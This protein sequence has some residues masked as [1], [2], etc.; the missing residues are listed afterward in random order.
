MKT[1]T[2]RNTRQ[3][4][5]G[6]GGLCEERR[7]QDTAKVP[8]RSGSEVRGTDASVCEDANNESIYM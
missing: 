6:V 3:E 1:A 8:V 5:L 4:N 7:V 2:S